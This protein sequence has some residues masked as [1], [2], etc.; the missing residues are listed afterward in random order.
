[1]KKLK[2]IAKFGEEESPEN[3]VEVN[4]ILLPYPSVRKPNCSMPQ[5]YSPVSSRTTEELGDLASQYAQWYEYL[6]ELLVIAKV[7][8]I[9]AKNSYENK[10]SEKLWLAESRTTL[11]EKKASVEA[12]TEIV[13]L[14]NQMIQAEC[15]FV[16]L[17]NKVLTLD[18][19]LAI[20]SREFSRRQ[21]MY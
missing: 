10:F 6:N 17:E 20:L 15:E 18:R 16:L 19:V 13:N 11:K 1:M 21:V 3:G 9:K 4:E 12:N 14:K 7:A 2:R 5:F 8:F